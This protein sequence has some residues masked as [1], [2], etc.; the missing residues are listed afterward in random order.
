MAKLFTDIQTVFYRKKKKQRIGLLSNQNQTAQQLSVKC[1]WKH[2]TRLVL[3]KLCLKTARLLANTLIGTS[4]LCRKWGFAQVTQTCSNTHIMMEMFT[5][6]LNSIGRG[7]RKFASSIVSLISFM[8]CG[9][10]SDA[11]QSIV[12]NINQVFQDVFYGITKLI[13]QSRITFSFVTF[14]NKFVTT[15]NSTLAIFYKIQSL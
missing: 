15:I 7:L 9:G 13:N 1:V 5:I 14:K 4:R 6:F 8:F 10:I 12:F 2:W 11:W 3:R